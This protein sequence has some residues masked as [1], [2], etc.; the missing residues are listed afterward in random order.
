M[1]SIYMD[2]N[3]GVLQQEKE[4]GI[5]IKY[6][7]EKSGSRII[8]P[9]IKRKAGI[10]KG[11]QYYDIV[12]PRGQCGPWVENNGSISRDELIEKFNEEFKKYCNSENIVAE[13]VKFSPWIDDFNDFSRIYNT[14]FYGYLYCNDLTVDFF[15]DEYKSS[16]RR[17]IKKAQKCGVKIE[18]DTTSKSI[19]DFLRIYDFTTEKYNVSDYYVLSREFLLKYFEILP[20]KVFFA[21]ALYE[22]E[23]ISSAMILMGDDIAH[24]HFATSNPNFK[25]LQGNVLLMYEASLYASQK[26]MKL[27]DLGGATPESALERFKSDLVDRG[28]YPY[29]IGTKI[30]NITIYEELVKQVGGPRE[31]YFPAYRR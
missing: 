13:Y 29:Y 18:I 1:K 3:W 6:T 15:A 20:N 9:F 23:V 19:D 30:H 4:D 24:Y 21:N 8:Y 27:F 2:E 22:G 14:K 17:N 16:K 28:K 11:A 10:I 26:G 25:S 7:F 5:P 12:T 31:G